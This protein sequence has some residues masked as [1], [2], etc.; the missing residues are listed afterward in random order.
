MPSREENSHGRLRVVWANLTFLVGYSPSSITL[1]GHCQLSTKTICLLHSNRVAS[2]KW[3]PSPSLQLAVACAWFLTIVNE[4]WCCGLLQDE[5]FKKKSCPILALLLIGYSW[6]EIH[7]R[8]QGPMMEGNQIH[9]S[10]I[11]ESHPLICNSHP[12]LWLNKYT[13]MAFALTH[14]EVCLFQQIT[15]LEILD[16]DDNIDHYKSSHALKI[17]HS[18]AQT[19]CSVQD[20]FSGDMQVNFFPG[21][22]HWSTHTPTADHKTYKAE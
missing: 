20:T 14:F 11:E 3:L 13:S 15:F 18:T 8:W 16:N 2:G 21:G 7:Q 9:E 6:L 19:F 10:V 17:F 1:L 4:S 5:V 22:Y 12:G